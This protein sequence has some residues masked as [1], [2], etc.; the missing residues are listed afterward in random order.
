MNA[1]P[2]IPACPN[3]PFTEFQ[4]GQKIEFAAQFG[5]Q[6]IDQFAALSGDWNPLHVDAGYATATPFRQQVVHGM[7]V[8]SLLSRVAGMYYP[9][10]QALLLQADHIAF[11][12]PVLVDE[13]L[14][15]VAE[16][17]AAHAVLR[18][19]VV[20]V[21]ITGR[22]GQLKLSGQ[23]KVRH[24]APQ[25]PPIISPNLEEL[26]Q[27]DLSNHVALVTGASRGIGAAI[28]EALG[29][30]HAK[31]AVNY[32]TADTLAAAVS[33]RIEAAGGQALPVQADVTRRA[34]VAHMVKQ[35]RAALGPIDLFVHNATA[36]LENLAFAETPWE[37]MQ[38]DF[39][40]HVAGAFHCLQEILPDM[41][42]NKFGRI[43]TMLTV[44]MQAPPPKGYT[45]YTTAKSGLLGLTR[46]VAAEYG[47]FGITA[48]MVAPGMVNTDLT[49]GTDEIAKKSLALRIPAGRIANPKDVVGPVLFFLSPAVGYINGAVLDVNGGLQF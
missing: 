44:I 42:R 26:M 15:C 5:R 13:S 30:C 11:H 1:R 43:V 14:Q 29:R 38:R 28:A 2:S 8:S 36:P 12:H 33:Q 3:P 34:D 4:V 31:V 48:N 25:P 20:T 7:L 21:H 39:E 37:L 22:Y 23:I 35:T 40:V 45:P 49:A 46:S 27:T 41:A 10:Q 18:I 47:R 24:R 6:A 17:V 32:H 9:G 16:I 19:L